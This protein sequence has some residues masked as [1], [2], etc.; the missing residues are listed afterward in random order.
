MAKS[1][2]DRTPEDGER[3]HRRGRQARRP[4]SDSRL[5]SVPIRL[6]RRA[7]DHE[8]DLITKAWNEL[9]EEASHGSKTAVS[10]A[11]DVIGLDRTTID[12]VKHV[13]AATLR[14]IL[15]DTER[16]VAE[17]R[18][19]VQ[20]ERIAAEQAAQEHR[21]HVAEVASSITFGD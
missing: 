5:Y 20:R 11:G 6:S 1:R 8:A 16:R 21:W 18:A 3:N 12:E 17:L 7:T 10:V 14:Q 2:H 9:P 13:H 15:Q 4:R 19:R